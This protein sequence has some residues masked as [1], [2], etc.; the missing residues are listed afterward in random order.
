M[1]CNGHQSKS[2]ST[3]GSVTDI[4]LAMSERVKSMATGKKENHRTH[5]V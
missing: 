5:C 1:R 2:K 3:N 4:G